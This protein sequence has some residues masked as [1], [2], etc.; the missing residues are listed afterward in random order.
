PNSTASFLVLRPVAF[1][2]SFIRVSSE[3]GLN[4]ES[5]PVLDTPE[6]AACTPVVLLP[7][8]MLACGLPV[9]N[10]ALAQPRGSAP[11]TREA[12]RNPEDAT[13][14]LAHSE[15]RLQSLK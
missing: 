10:G 9:S 1:R 12:A 6:G 15:G 2:A 7:V 3:T 4:G 5:T 13:T 8:L 14:Q 11:T